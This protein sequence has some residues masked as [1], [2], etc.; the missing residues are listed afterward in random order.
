MIRKWFLLLLFLA[1]SVSAQVS[2][3]FSDGDFSNNP[4]WTGETNFFQVTNQELQ[5]NGPNGTDT[6][7]LVTSS[8]VAMNCEWRFYHRLEFNP[9]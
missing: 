4:T 1:T 7:F 3:D 2:D 9:S 6:I 5:S 8:S